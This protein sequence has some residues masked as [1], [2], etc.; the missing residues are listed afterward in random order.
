[1]P[2]GV[3]ML[4]YQQCVTNKIS[5]LLA[6]HNIKTIHNPA[7]KIIHM[8]GSVKFKLGLKVPGIYCTPCE[9]GKVYIGQTGRTIETQCKEHKRHIH[10][11]QPDKPAVAE[12]SIEAGHNIDFNNITILDKVTGCM[13]LI[14]KEATEICLH[15]NNFNRAGGFN[16]S[17]AWQTVTNMLKLSGKP[18]SKQ[19][20]T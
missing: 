7:R 8:L 6:I 5:R 11:G 14:V 3:A 15:P 12:H 4:P 10:L 16:L 19:D 18:I 20:Q 2:T 9:S 13:D 17:R 1:M